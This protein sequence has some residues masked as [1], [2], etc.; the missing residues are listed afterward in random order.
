MQTTNI[1]SPLSAEEAAFLALNGDEFNH[2]VTFLDFAPESLTIGF[3]A[4]DFPRDRETLFHLLAQDE[5]CQDVQFEM[6]HCDD[7]KLRFLRDQLIVEMPKRIPLPGKKLVVVITGLE[8]SIGLL[9]EYPPVLQDLNYVREG[10]T[11]T[12]PH[13]LLICIPDT[14][15]T[16]LAKF[17]PDFW[18][19]RRAVLQFQTLPS[20]REAAI[21]ET[22]R[23][24]VV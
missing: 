6:F 10:F 5:R 17:A 2:L 20:T 13:P 18:A 8:E 7:R 9:G 21:A 23:K 19:W 3:V 14:T 1:K 16:R 12:V 24:S 15:L 22:D 11:S 4:I